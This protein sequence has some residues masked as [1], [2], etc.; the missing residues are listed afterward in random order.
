MNNNPDPAQLDHPFES[1]LNK[2][3]L[4]FRL[5]STRQ[6]VYLSLANPALSV[7]TLMHNELID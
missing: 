1:M 6:L 2:T 5:S 3:H 7:E 4:P